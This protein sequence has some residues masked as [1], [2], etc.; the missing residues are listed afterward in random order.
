M[1]WSCYLQSTTVAFSKGKVTFRWKAY[2]D[3][4]A[5]KEMTRDVREFTRRFLLHTLPRGF[6]RIRHYGFL[7]SPAKV[8][9]TARIAKVDN[10]CTVLA[11]PQPPPI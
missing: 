6:L 3:G 5:V 4:N 1:P 8:I 2:A 11:A 10:A 9:V 7:Y